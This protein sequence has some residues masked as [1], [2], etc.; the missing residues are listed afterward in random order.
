VTVLVTGA[1]GLLGSHLIDLLTEQGERPRALV[2]P[3]E[4]PDGP[5]GA[6]AEVCWGDLRDRSA[7]DAAL[8]G[9][10]CVLHCAARTGPWGPEAEYE[11]VNVRGLE[12]LVNAARAA[13]VRRIVHVSSIT[14]HGN[15]VRGVADETAPFQVE[16]NPYSRSKV[17]GERL[18]ARMIEEQGAPVT[19]VRPGWIYGPRDAA[20][21]GRFA[22]MIRAGRMIMIGSGENHVPLIYVRDAAEGVRLAGEA[23]QASGRTYLLVNDE[24][25]TQRSYL[26]AI[27]AELGAPVP[28]RHI[29]YRLALLLGSAAEG[30]A[31]ATRRQQAPPLTRYGI[32]LLGG[33]NQFVITRARQELGFA[34]QVGVAEGV[35]RA[36]AWY[37]D[38]LDTEHRGALVAERR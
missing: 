7:I 10:E 18:L 26:S 12:T 24:P 29:P 35:R 20:S 32:Q 15:D 5:A 37:R 9:V 27:A 22:A 38:T 4:S 3:G 14:V 28:K 2:R 1:T 33:E 23:D 36:A 34:P 17:A 25:V 31:R 6:G 16:S 11:S 13:G 8:V 30:A 19:I 21:F